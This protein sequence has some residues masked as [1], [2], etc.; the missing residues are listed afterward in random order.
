MENFNF[1]FTED[2]LEDYLYENIEKHYDMKVIKRQFKIPKGR[3]DIIAKSNKEKDMYYVIEIKTGNIDANSVCQILR[4]SNYLN[5]ELSKQGKR[6]FV[7]LL[8]GRNLSNEN[9]HVVY[10]LKK[11]D[12]TLKNWEVQQNKI[13]YSLYNIDFSGIDFSYFNPTNAE[14]IDNE[15]KNNFSRIEELALDRH[16][17]KMDVEKL[18]KKIITLKKKIK[19][20]K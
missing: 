5:S 8:I 9:N 1:K 15:F 6:I 20:A 2:Q 14:Y 3:I 18:V 19:D 17:L 12:S 16:Y 4:Y 11:H 7:P 13:Y 10:L